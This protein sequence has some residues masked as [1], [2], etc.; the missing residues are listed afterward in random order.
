MTGRIGYGLALAIILLAG[1]GEEA[2]GP[3]LSLPAPVLLPP[4]SDLAEEER[5]LDAVPD[6][7]AIQIEWQRYLDEQAAV[8]IYRACDRPVSFAKIASVG[9]RDTCYLDEGVAIGRR[10]W[11]FL[12]ARRG[13]E[14]SRPSDTLSYR[15]LDKPYALSEEGGRV[16]IFRWQV[17]EVPVAYVIKLFDG[18]ADTRVWF[19]VV[20]PDYGALVEQVRFN[21]DGSA[22]VDSLVS[23][24]VYRWRV[25]VVAPEAAA[26]AE[27]NWRLFLCP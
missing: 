24:R 6:R 17:R 19:A 21:S 25:D 5:G 1:C 14:R 4:P 23:G 2:A 8:E 22:V 7:D 18:T 26:G 16:P 11:Y 27:S 3:R 13:S 20:T 10:Y 9:A 15:L 12:V